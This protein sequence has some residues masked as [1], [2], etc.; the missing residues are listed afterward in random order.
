MLYFCAVVCIRSFV[1]PLNRYQIQSLVDLCGE[2]LAATLS[3]EDVCE[4]FMLADQSSAAVLKVRL[5]SLII[6]SLL[7]LKRQER[8]LEY[9]ATDKQRLRAIRM[10]EGYKKLT[11]EQ[12]CSLARWRWFAVSQ[13][14]F[15]RRLTPLLLR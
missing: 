2:K 9:M 3:V 8:C 12:V 11:R 13:P 6:P 14:T 5:H 15:T 4:R 7:L 10:T 1:L